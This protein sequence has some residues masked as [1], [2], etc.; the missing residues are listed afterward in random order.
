[1]S[2]HLEGMGLLGSLLAWQLDR[3]KVPFSWHDSDSQTAAWRASTG[4]A[5]PSG[6]FQDMEALALWQAWAES[7][8]WPSLPTVCCKASFWY[9]SKHPPH[10]A[11]YR[12]RVDLGALRMAPIPSVHLDVRSFVRHTREHFKARRLN[13]RPD[14]TQVIVAHG[15]DPRRLRRVIWG[16]SARVRLGLSDKLLEQ[17]QPTCLYL[18]VGRYQMAYAYP[19]PGTDLHFAGSSMVVQQQPKALEIE[20][21]LARWIEHL[22]RTSGGHARVLDVIETAQGWRPDAHP[23][24]AAWVREIDGDLVVRPM[25]A[26]GMR[27]GPHVLRAVLEELRARALLPAGGAGGR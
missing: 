16:W 7:P 13:G 22:E 9:S 23:D 4:C 19:V 14:G 8:P 5:Y 18:R 20:S 3:Y 27:H 17:P 21:K 1:M 11:K 12:P 25:Q 26:S 15:F 10:A 24:D 2:V 6:H